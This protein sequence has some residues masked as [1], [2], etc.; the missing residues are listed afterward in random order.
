MATIHTNRQTNNSLVHTQINRYR[1][2]F[3][4]TCV[5]FS[6]L[7][8]YCTSYMYTQILKSPSAKS[9]WSLSSFTHYK[10][11]VGGDNHMTCWCALNR[12]WPIH[13]AYTSVCMCTVLTRMLARF[14]CQWHFHTT[15]SPPSTTYMYKL[16]WH[17]T[18]L[19][20]KML[21]WGEG[22]FMSYASLSSW[23]FSHPSEARHN[24]H[25][26][27]SGQ[28]FNRFHIITAIISSSISEFLLSK[29]FNNYLYIV[30]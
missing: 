12:I 1:A 22:V 14:C 3:T 9:P 10:N 26:E 21:Q 30:Q 13:A 25:G 27:N 4:D 17:V 15:G 18:H 6:L 20:I 28:I 23:L 11:E 5:L 7:Y 16:K 19:P 2:R 29:F 8:T 24:K